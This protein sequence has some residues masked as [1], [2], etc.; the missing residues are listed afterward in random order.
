MSEKALKKQGKEVVTMKKIAKSLWIKKEEDVYTV[1]LTAELQDD[2]GTVGYVEYSQKEKLEKDDAILRLEASKTVLDI[3]TPLA[4]DV[5][6]YNKEAET[7]PTVLNE[8]DDKAWVVKLT[9]VNE[10]EFNQLT[11]F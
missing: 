3:N 7:T 1:G 6:E 8:A 5:V 2:V 4:G 10:E 9:N 11:D